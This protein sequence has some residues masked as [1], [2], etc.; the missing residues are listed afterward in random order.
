MANYLWSV[1][2]SQVAQ[3][4]RPGVWE[5]FADLLLREGNFWNEFGECGAWRLGLGEAFGEHSHLGYRNERSFHDAFHQP[6][7]QIMKPNGQAKHEGTFA[8]DACDAFDGIAQ[9]QFFRTQHGDG[10][11]GEP[12]IG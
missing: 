9:G 3:V 10:L 2:T 5:S 4:K 1:A 6:A 11:F 8:D 7:E 12:A